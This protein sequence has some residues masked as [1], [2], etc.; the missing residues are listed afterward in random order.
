MGKNNYSVGEAAPGTGGGAE[1][2]AVFSGVRKTYDG[3]SY[4]VKSLDLSIRRG[5]FLTLLGPSG[6]GK[7]TTLMMLAGFEDPTEGHIL[8]NGRAIEHVPPY[9]RNIGMVF[10]QYALFPHMT[11]EENIAFPLRARHFPKTE[12]GARVKRA[13]DIVRLPGLGRRKPTELSGGQQQRVALARAIVF[14]PEIVLMDEPLGALD[15]QLREQMQIEIRRL[16]RELGVTVVYVTHDQSEAL[17]MSDRIAVFEGGEIQQLDAP[18]TIYESPRTTF[19]ANFLGE[20]NLICG[21]VVG[22]DGARW[23]IRMQSGEIVTGVSDRSLAE[24]ET[25]MLGI[26]PERTVVGDAA[27]TADNRVTARVREAYYLGDHLRLRLRCFGDCEILVKMP[28]LDGAPPQVDEEIML[29]WSADHC[30]VLPG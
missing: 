19:V 13:L 12:I 5:E 2:I 17:T 15:K 27:R 28:P 29:G 8:L 11:A 23:R 30:R 4:A 10:Q 3:V 1:A 16:H 25:A 6:S 26:R 21:K 20:N 24:G 7:T 22:R 14:D 9:R 18:A